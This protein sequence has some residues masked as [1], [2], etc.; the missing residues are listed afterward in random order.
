MY[1]FLFIVFLF[2]SV[3]CRA[4]ENIESERLDNPDI[5]LNG[6]VAFNLDGETGSSEKIAFGTELKLIKSTQ[7]DEI[8]FLIEQDY[9]EVNDDKNTDKSFVHL[10]Y[11]T[12]DTPNWGHEVF[13]QAENDEFRALRS[14]YLLGLGLRYTLTPVNKLSANILGLGLFYEKEEYELEGTDNDEKNIR[15]NFYWTYKHKISDYAALR[16]TFYFQP[17]L[18]DVSDEK[19]LWVFSVT[20]SITEKL[21]LRISVDVVHDTKTPESVVATETSYETEI[22]YAF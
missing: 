13:V 8:I 12:K 7:R 14:R 18:N 20:S 2:F 16:S 6:S 22:V 4:I 19:G 17:K 9:A 15:G 21:L 5:G 11:L 3:N 1:R 10:R